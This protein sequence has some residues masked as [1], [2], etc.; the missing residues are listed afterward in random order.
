MNNPDSPGERGSDQ[1]TKRDTA[2]ILKHRADRICSLIVASDYPDIDIDI[3][4]RNLRSW[5]ADV[6]PERREL[7]EI[8]YESRFRR[9]REQFRS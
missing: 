5:C 1:R 6:L 2:E 9:L 8:I 7:F 3:E 4:I